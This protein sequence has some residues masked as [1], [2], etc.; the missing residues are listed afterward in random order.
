MCN[1]NVILMKKSNA[2]Q[3]YKLKNMRRG[4]SNDLKS[5]IY[6]YLIFCKYWF[7]I[8]YEYNSNL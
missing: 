2:V 7:H 3:H 4:L 5:V 1:L 6:F 8:E